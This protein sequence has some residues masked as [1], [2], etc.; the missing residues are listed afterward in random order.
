MGESSIWD[1]N[2]RFQFLLLRLCQNH[3][4]SFLKQ[5]S[6][7]LPADSDSLNLDRALGYV[8]E[9]LLETWEGSPGAELHNHPHPDMR[10]VILGLDSHSQ[11]ESLS[12]NSFIKG[13]G[14]A[15]K[16]TVHSLQETEVSGRQLCLPNDSGTEGNI[17]MAECSNPLAS[18]NI[19]KLGEIATEVIFMSLEVTISTFTPLWTLL[20]VVRQPSPLADGLPHPHPSF[21]H[22]RVPSCPQGMHVDWE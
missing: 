12:S 1:R 9:E 11:P 5:G 14:S 17:R 16:Q 20:L 18:R 4:E 22:C 2:S 6:L 15:L 10:S 19:A 8:S 7:G 13:T 21:L 3:L